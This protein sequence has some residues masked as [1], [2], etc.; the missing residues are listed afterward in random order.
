VTCAGITDEAVTG[1]L[2]TVFERFAECG[3]AR[4]V[5]L[6]FRSEGLMFPLP[7]WPT[8]PIQW[9]APSSH[10]IHQVLTNPVYAGA[11]V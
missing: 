11:Y 5:W 4:R 1:A 9:V 2:R 3:S 7:Q 8:H 10:A 6:W